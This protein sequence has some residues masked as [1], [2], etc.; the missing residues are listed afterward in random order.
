MRL[1]SLLCC[2]CAGFVSLLA[3]AAP[4][5]VVT[6]LDGGAGLLRGLGHYTL[7]EGVKLEPGDVVEVSEK[8]F[9]Q[10]ELGDGSILA[11]GPR[12]RFLSFP[13]VT[14]RPADEFFLLQGPLK[15]EAPKSSTDAGV[16]VVTAQFS[17]QVAD[18]N[19]V[20]LASA[21]E[22]AL[23]MERGE[24]RIRD[25]GRQGAAPD[26]VLLKGNAFYVRKTDQEGTIDTRPPQTFVAALPKAFL[27]RLP[28]RLAQFKD[29]DA[30]PQKA[31]DFTYPD[32]EAWLKGP[33]APRKVL[34]PRWRPKA[35]DPA[36]RS[37]LMANLKDHPEWDRI[38]FPEKYRPKPKAIYEPK[39]A[40]QVNPA[41]SRALDQP[42]AAAN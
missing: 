3:S 29:V 18:A 25:E 36:F 14:G 17:L 21:D 30:P 37:G 27:D 42:K 39:P 20:V 16:H 38:L 8:G 10:I 2:V 23:F 7:S 32:V 41:E 5:G 28:A 13:P 31:A 33:A 22:S 1:G 15:V 19:A 6:L 24:T 26:P 11:L 34:V 35:K 12:A 9:A 4:F 40:E